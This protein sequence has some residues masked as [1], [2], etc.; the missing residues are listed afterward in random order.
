MLCIQ[1]SLSRQISK[2]CIQT[3][4]TCVV[5]KIEKKNTFYDLELSQRDCFFYVSFVG[6]E[7]VYWFLTRKIENN[8]TGEGKKCPPK[9]IKPW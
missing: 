1:I 8:G 5:T 7:H 2:H 9:Q 6:K 4:N 3:E